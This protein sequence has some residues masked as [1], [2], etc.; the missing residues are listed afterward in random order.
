[1]GEM[2][3]ERPVAGAAGK[4]ASRPAP[5]TIG[6]ASE[7]DG[8]WRSPGSAVRL[9]RH[10]SPLLNINARR[11]ALV[12]GSRP[13]ARVRPGPASVRSFSS[14]GRGSSPHRTFGRLGS[15]KYQRQYGT[16]PR[17]AP[18][19]KSNPGVGARPRAARASRW[20]SGRTARPRQPWRP[21]A[22][23]AAAGRARSAPRRGRP[24]TPAGPP[25]APG[26]R[27]RSW[28]RGNGPLNSVEEARV[29]GVPEGGG[30]VVVDEVDRETAP[31]GLGEPDDEI[32]RRV[33]A[34]RA[35]QVQAV[36]ASAVDE[37]TVQPDQVRSAVEVAGAGVVLVF[38]VRRPAAGS[39]PT[40]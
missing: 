5:R 23:T 38:R 37:F 39:T 2:Y 8:T 15:R 35:D 32:R 31:V 26:R 34:N 22:G 14:G 36:G 20:R 27:R 6:S 21:C 28:C 3:S 17:A 18:R 9:G 10:G 19:I 24:A 11:V 29:E 12:A 30:P 13:S 1:M 7:Y 33:A 25:R 4:A 40:G 16:C